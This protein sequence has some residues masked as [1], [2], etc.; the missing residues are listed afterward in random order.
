MYDM[1]H[2]LLNQSLLLRHLLE[3]MQDLIS[4]VAKFQNKLWFYS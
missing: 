1:C 2:N 4:Q 3:I